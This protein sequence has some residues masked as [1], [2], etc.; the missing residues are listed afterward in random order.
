ME[1]F[2]GFDSQPAKTSKTLNDS[3]ALPEI[4]AKIK[5]LEVW[6]RGGEKFLT[7]FLSI[8][9]CNATVMKYY[10]VGAE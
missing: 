6:D 9:N 5:D 1:V 4:F 2:A 8:L 7:N 10:Y 3:M